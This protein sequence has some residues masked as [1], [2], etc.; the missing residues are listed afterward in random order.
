[1]IYSLPL[2]INKQWVSFDFGFNDNPPQLRLLLLGYMS[3][4]PV[5]TPNP[6]RQLLLHLQSQNDLQLRLRIRRR[7]KVSIRVLT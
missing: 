2:E 5:V 1:M 6:I 7:L 3:A 4:D